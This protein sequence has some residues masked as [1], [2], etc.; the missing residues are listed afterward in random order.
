MFKKRWV[1]NDIREGYSIRE[2]NP[3]PFPSFPPDIDHDTRRSSQQ[4]HGVR[5]LTEE[6]ND[7][8]KLQ[9]LHPRPL[10]I[11]LLEWLLLAIRG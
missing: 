9:S 10:P 1:I 3:N 5:L 6:A 4:A 11:S 8:W 7:R 2:N